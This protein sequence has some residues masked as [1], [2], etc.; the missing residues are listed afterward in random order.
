MYYELINKILR[1]RAVRAHRQLNTAKGFTI[2]ELLIV[3][4]VIAILA[5]ITMVSYTGIQARATI[6]QQTTALRQY[7]NAYNQYTIQNGQYAYENNLPNDDYGCVYPATS[8]YSGW[9]STLTATLSTNMQSYGVNDLKFNNLVLFNYGSP[10]IGSSYTGQ[11][12]YVLY[13]G[14]IACPSVGGLRY[15]STGTN[16]SNTSCRY[17]PQ[18]QP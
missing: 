14:S 15:L 5:A 3:I 18:S 13:A 2:V 6:N 4:V 16:G 11:Y 1:N 9:S 17:A 12:Y 8:C 7:A 10:V